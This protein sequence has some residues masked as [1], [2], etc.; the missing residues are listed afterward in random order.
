[1]RFWR[2]TG[3]LETLEYVNPVAVEGSLSGLFTYAGEQA[4]GQLCLQIEN[5][6]VDVLTE[7]LKAAIAPGQ[8]ID[9]LINPE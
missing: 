6:Q 9:I 7:G 2:V 1:M 4:D 8:S 5:M 3:Q